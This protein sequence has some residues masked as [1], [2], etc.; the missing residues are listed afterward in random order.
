MKLQSLVTSGKYKDLLFVLRYFNVP[1]TDFKG[2]ARIDMDE[3]E[4]RDLLTKYNIKYETMNETY[5]R[6]TFVQIKDGI[7]NVSLSH[8]SY[9]NN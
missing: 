7:W 3:D 6:S 8:N 5:Y 9:K 1:Y 4:F 2:V